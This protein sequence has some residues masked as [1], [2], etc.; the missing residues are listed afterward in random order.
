MVATRTIRTSKEATDRFTEVNGVKVHY[1]EAGSG[2]ALICFHGGGPGANAWDNTKGCI[3]ELSQ[4][5]RTILMD[6]PA[7]GESDMDQKLGEEPLDIY[8]AKVVLGLMDQ[9]DIDRAHL[10]SS[11]Q[12]GPMTLR[13]GIEYPDRTG[14]IVMQSSGPERG[15]RLMFQPSPPEGLKA[16]AKFG[17]SPTREN[18]EAM[19]RLFYPNDFFNDDLVEARFKAAMRPGHLEARR[20]FASSK[21]SDVSKELQRLKAEVLVVWGYQ[22]R[23]V[24]V[25]S[26][27]RCLALI[28]N[29]RVHIWG[30][31]SGHF[32][33]AEHPDEFSRLLIGFLTP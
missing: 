31:S 33:A 24:P 8:W 10:Y 11:S 17:E 29:C 32:V 16:I 20:E 18:M 26:A 7:F 21:N 5:F 28:P 1:N 23:M 30:G 2:P 22:D 25:E 9:L 6:L 27:M 4:H 15:G 12:S 19:V 13:F 3:D 14:K